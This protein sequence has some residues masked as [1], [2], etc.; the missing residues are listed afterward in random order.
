MTSQTADLQRTELKLCLSSE[1][2]SEQ[3]L[4]ESG[5][6]QIQMA[7]A[8]QNVKRDDPFIAEA[9]FIPFYMCNNIGNINNDTMWMHFVFWIGNLNEI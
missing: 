6:T 9:R 8:V 5:H 4:L 1:G 3:S 7:H 2:G